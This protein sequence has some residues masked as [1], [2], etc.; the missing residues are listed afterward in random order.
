M[1]DF[2]KPLDLQLSTGSLNEIVQSS[3]ILVAETAQKKGVT[4]EN[5]LSPGPPG[6]CL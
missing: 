3:L 1:L 6:R 4:I 5:L 2:S